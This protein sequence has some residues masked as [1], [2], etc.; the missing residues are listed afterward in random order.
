MRPDRKTTGAHLC[1]VMSCVSATTAAV[2][3]LLDSCH[4]FG[5]ETGY[6]RLVMC[7]LGIRQQS[8]KSVNALLKVHPLFK[9]HGY[10]TL[11]PSL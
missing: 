2:T 4:Q 11:R 7:L 3:T 10:F 6:L 1:A 9:I 8:F 5:T